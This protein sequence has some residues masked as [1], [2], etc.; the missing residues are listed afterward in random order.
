MIY[1]ELMVGEIEEK[2][3]ANTAET[4]SKYI[5]LSNRTMKR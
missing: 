1:K 5:K 2:W 3:I 4:K